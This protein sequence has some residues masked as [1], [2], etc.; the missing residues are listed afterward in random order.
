[1]RRAQNLSLQLDALAEKGALIL[2][3]FEAYPARA[4][5]S[6]RDV[7]AAMSGLQSLAAQLGFLREQ[8]ELRCLGMGW[9]DLSVSWSHGNETTDQ[10]IKRL[11]SHLRDSVLPIEAERIR[12]GLMPNEAPLPD[13]KAKSLKQLG[14]ATADSTELASSALCSPEQLQASIERERER[15][16]AAGLAD[17]VQALQPKEAP[18]IDE[19][20]VGKLLEV[21]WNYIS[22]EDGVSKV[23]HAPQIPQ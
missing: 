1:M 4:I 5:C 7:E 23:D 16:I 11:G 15:R 2:E 20:L 8:I 19:Q 21:C 22:T 18:E 17:D 6:W 14:S 9:N 3:R 12:D 13:F 10:S